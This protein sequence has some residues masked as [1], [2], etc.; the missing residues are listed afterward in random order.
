MRDA[1]A[2]GG[3]KEYFYR[4]AKD[5]EF[6]RL[7]SHQTTSMNLFS[8]SM[9]SM[10]KLLRKSKKVKRGATLEEAETDGA[11]LTV[12]ARIARR[13]RDDKDLGVSRYPYELSRA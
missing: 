5:N 8:D 1:P 7:R 11:W 10:E 12:Y 2:L 4:R 13:S 9:Q 6:K 3:W